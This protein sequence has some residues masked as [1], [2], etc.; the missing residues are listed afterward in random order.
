MPRT[1][2]FSPDDALVVVTELFLQRGFTALSMGEIAAA[3]DLSRAT[4][5]ITW[6]NKVRLFVTVMERYGPARLPGLREL[7]DA[8]SPRAALIRLFALAIT[9]VAEQRCLVLGTIMELPRRPLQIDRL[10]DRAVVDLERRFREAIE[11]GQAAGEIADGVEPVQTARILFS[12][13]LGVY[14]LV[15]SG[16]PG[17]VPVLGS[18][19]AQV[20][21]LL[22]APA[23]Q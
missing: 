13:Y 23:A 8:P 21:A 2:S 12:L 5:Y 9:G 7:Y 16:A 20:K 1:K 17:A 6:G 4:V 14:V 19:M 15:R 18:V 22:P 3:L 11:R 10:I